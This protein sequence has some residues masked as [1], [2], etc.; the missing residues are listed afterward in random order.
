VRKGE[1]LA[2]TPNDSLQLIGRVGQPAAGGAPLG[3]R[4]TLILALLLG[5][6]S[7]FMSWHIVRIGAINL[8]L[9]DVAFAGC[10][11][12]L[13]VRGR[14]NPM[15]LGE[16]T[17]VWILGLTLLL[18][19]ML[20]GSMIHG[21]PVRW[22]VVAGQ[23]LFA[24]LLL[25]MVLMS[26]DRAMLRRYLL[27]YALGVAASQ[28]IAITASFFFTFRDTSDLLGWDFITGL[29][30]IG[31]FSG[32][33]NW[34]AA[35]IGFALPIL[36]NAYQHS[37]IGAKAALLCAVPLIWGL[38]ATASV[39]GLAATSLAMLL[40][41]GAGTPA[42]L[43]RFGLPL[44]LLGGIYVGTGMPLPAAFEQRVGSALST[45]N[46]NEAG[47]F[48]GRSALAKEAWKAADRTIL[49]G[50]GADGF[51]RASVHGMPV[52]VLPLLI[53]T[54]GGIWSA[55]GLAVMIATLAAATLR[56]LG[57]D[58][59]D[60]AMAIAI[61]TVFVVFMFAMPHMYARLWIGPLILALGLGLTSA[62]SPRDPARVPQTRRRRAHAARRRAGAA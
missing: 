40:Y 44:A 12:L 62:S 28:T 33:A 25:P 1:T 19:G 47:T 58:R 34:N 23:Y 57:G 21:D 37:R 61:L 20:L 35:C 29:G 15:P 59:S 17:H 26:Q 6:G 22:L 56:M 54:E 53:L 41:F 9:S 3:D 5:F 39:T 38:F 13:A 42:M 52:H 45:G 32:N 27:Y 49:V 55:L 10:L 36:L 60:A 46:L 8:T 51:R 50:L 4:L 2:V 48:E 24:Y 18:G 11:V 16:F 31:A 7:F 30:R 43:L 14:L